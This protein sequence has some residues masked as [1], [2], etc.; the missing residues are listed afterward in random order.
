MY[1]VTFLSCN[2]E[3]KGTF[4]IRTNCT[5]AVSLMGGHSS[6]PIYMYM[7]LHSCDRVPM[8][9]PSGTVHT[10]VHVHTCTRSCTCINGTQ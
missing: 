7:Y 4:H 2:L 3:T 6:H 10:N 9:L 5:Q 8:C 1:R